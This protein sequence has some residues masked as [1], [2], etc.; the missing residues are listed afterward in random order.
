MSD[1]ITRAL[2]LGVAL[3]LFALAFSAFIY[4]YRE[5]SGYFS[6]ASGAA[7]PFGTAEVDTTPVQAVMTGDEVISLVLDKRGDDAD[8][9]LREL[10]GAARGSADSL[11]DIRIGGMS[12]ADFDIMSID[13]NGRY[14]A[15]YAFD[16]QG[17]PV[18]VDLEPMP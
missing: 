2:Y 8:T 16:R 12:C 13:V 7:E 4:S 14:Y 15:A 18:S 3:L 5:L 1:N 6:A 10:Y 9:L 11:P 17:N